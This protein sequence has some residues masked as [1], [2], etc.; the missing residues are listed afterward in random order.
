MSKRWINRKVVFRWDGTK[1]IEVYA[2]KYLYEGE[3]AWADVSEWAG[4]GGGAGG[5]GGGNGG[6]AIIVTSNLTNS[7]VYSFNVSGGAK[8]IL[9]YANGVSGGGNSGNHG[10]DGTVGTD[11]ISLA[12]VV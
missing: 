11:G 4:H 3:I 8:G 1:Y 6:V 10:A 2:D 12:V 7:S 5:G 9:G